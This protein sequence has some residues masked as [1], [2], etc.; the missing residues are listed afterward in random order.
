MVNVSLRSVVPVDMCKTEAGGSSNIV[1]SKII[2]I[3]IIIMKPQKSYHFSVLS[4]SL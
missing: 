1:R 4:H 3:I 2:I